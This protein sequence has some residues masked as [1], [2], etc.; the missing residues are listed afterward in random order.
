MVKIGSRDLNLD[1]N[2]NMAVGAIQV[3]QSAV[4]MIAPEKVGV[5]LA[6]LCMRF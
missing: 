5:C 3:A 6:A 2:L 1:Q 4:C